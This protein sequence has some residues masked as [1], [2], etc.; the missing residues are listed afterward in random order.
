MKMVTSIGTEMIGKMKIKEK[1][2][3]TSKTSMFPLTR[4]SL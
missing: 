2:Y 4:V 3:V 1:P